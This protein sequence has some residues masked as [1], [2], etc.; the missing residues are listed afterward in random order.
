MNE[1]I[2]DPG[3]RNVPDVDGTGALCPDW[4]DILNK[5]SVTATELL[6]MEITPRE[7]ILGDWFRQGDLGFIYGPRGLGKT[8]LSLAFAHAIA[9]GTKA[10]PWTAPKPRRV[11]YTDGEMALDS[12]MQRARALRSTHSENLIFIHH[13]LVFERTGQVLNLTAAPVQEALLQ[14]AIAN[15]IEVLVLDNLSC[16]FSGVKENDA[17]AWE[18]ILP[19]LLKL[20]R[21]RIAVIIVAHAGRNGHMRGTSRREDAAVWILSL[22]ESPSRSESIDG[23]NFVSRFTKNRNS[24][25]GAD[26]SL[27]WQ[28]LR[29]GS[30]GVGLFY[31]V[32]KCPIHFWESFRPCAVQSPGL[33]TVFQKTHWPCRIYSLPDQVVCS[34]GA[35][36]PPVPGSLL[37]SQ[38]LPVGENTIRKPSSREPPRKEK[39]LPRARSGLT[40]VSDTR[41][42]ISH[43]A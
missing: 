22:F 9:S 19:W 21:H 17:D 13:E 24:T 41:A 40:L 38:A 12:T 20:R 39:P 29:E 1:L 31:R 32:S 33:N 28:F 35:L 11:G 6:A 10:G 27:E 42:P 36:P 43:R 2:H 18:L 5:S 7:A 26:S 8:W 3:I 16:L 14:Y 25:G 15:N 23:A 37:Q 34:G 4:R 30:D